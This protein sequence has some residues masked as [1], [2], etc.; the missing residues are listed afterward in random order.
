[1]TII[2]NYTK[3][4]DIHVNNVLPLS[5]SKWRGKRV[6][7]SMLHVYQPF[8]QVLTA[9]LPYIGKLRYEC[10]NISSRGRDSCY[11]V[12][13]GVTGTAVKTRLLKRLQAL[14][15]NIM[16]TFVVKTVEENKA[17]HINY[18]EMRKE[19][20]V[21]LDS[22]EKLEILLKFFHHGFMELFQLAVFHW[23]WAVFSI[24]S[25]LTQ[26]WSALLSAT[27]LWSAFV[28]V[29]QRNWH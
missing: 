4:Y 27:T 2:S 5:R 14:N 24:T 10:K 3:I 22:M 17:M 18:Y 26:L 7:P 13:F 21:W 15:I 12:K 28:W 9:H 1:M 25:G 8:G 20:H 23:S 11:S 16:R 6:E 29:A 19:L